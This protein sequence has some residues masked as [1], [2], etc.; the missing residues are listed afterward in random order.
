L[1]YFQ[2]KSSGFDRKEELISDFKKGYRAEKA[3]KNQRKPARGTHYR[4]AE[5]HDRAAAIGATYG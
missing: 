1:S 4:I 2:D 3:L 5:N